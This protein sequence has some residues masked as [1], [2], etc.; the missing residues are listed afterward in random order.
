MNRLLLLSILTISI[1]II[2]SCERKSPVLGSGCGNSVTKYMKDGKIANYQIIF[3]TADIN[4]SAIQ[5]A[6]TQML[7]AVFQRKETIIKKYVPGLPGVAGVFP[8]V[9]FIPH[10]AYLCGKNVYASELATGIEQT[11]NNSNVYIKGDRVKGSTW[12]HKLNGVTYNMGLAFR[13]SGFICPVD[14]FHA[15]R[16]YIREGNA[17]VADT[18]YY[19]DTVGVLYFKGPKMQYIMTSKNY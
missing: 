16:I 4:D 12:S 19:N 3:S 13:D 10:Y 1:S 9:N 6:Y 8:K 17:T 11:P 15:D 7:P 2:S 5:I 14:T 18:I